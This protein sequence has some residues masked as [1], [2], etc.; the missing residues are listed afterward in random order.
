MEEAG[1]R[2]NG[3]R[4]SPIFLRQIEEPRLSSFLD[5]KWVQ[6]TFFLG[7][8]AHYFDLNVV[9]PRFSIVQVSNKND[10]GWVAP[11]D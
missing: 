8:G 10:S 11:W 2:E 5:G 1:S 7:A 9:C 4:V 6:T 3:G